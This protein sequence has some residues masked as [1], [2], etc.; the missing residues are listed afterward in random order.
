MHIYIIFFRDAIKPHFSAVFFYFTLFFHVMPWSPVYR[1]R[2]F[3]LNFPP[4]HR[5]VFAVSN[6]VSESDYH[7]AKYCRLCL[8]Q[9]N[10]NIGNPPG[11]Y[12]IIT[13]V[14][15]IFSLGFIVSGIRTPII[16]PE[17]FFLKINVRGCITRFRSL[18]DS[19][20]YI[21][22]C[23]GKRWPNNIVIRSQTI[24]M[25]YYNNH[26]DEMRKTFCIDEF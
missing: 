1:V 13:V 3:T 19:F 9:K 24:A 5:S 14:R 25:T 15:I 6:T 12:N 22:V 26:L 2:I 20:V 8:R 17:L 23:P 18:C 4:R 21:I 10:R 7:C 11:S 16:D